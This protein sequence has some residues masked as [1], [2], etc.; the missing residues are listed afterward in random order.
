MSRKSI[1]SKITQPYAEA[2]LEIA[3]NNDSIEIFNQDAQK[4]IDLV[5]QTRKLEDFLLN[6]LASIQ[7][8]KEVINKI[9]LD[10]VSYTTLKF[11]LVLADRNRIRFLSI[12]ME[13][14]LELAYKATSVEVVRV[15]SAIE[16][17][18]S[19]KKV[20]NKKLQEIT[21]ANYIKLIVEI[22]P[23]LIGGFSVQIGSQ[24]LDTTIKTQLNQLAYCLRVNV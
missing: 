17:T 5:S 8:K 7:T 14:Y 21:L 23:E 15:Y 18:E 24:V 13:K 12:I 19:Q 1:S 3:M 20:L 10:N 9:F 16:I 2:F 22:K 4:I 11:L 6:P